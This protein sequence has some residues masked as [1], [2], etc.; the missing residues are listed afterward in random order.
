MLNNDIRITLDHESI[1]K[2]DLY[3]EL[4]EL[5]SAFC[6][7]GQQQFCIDQQ[8]ITREEIIQMKNTIQQIQTL[9]PTSDHHNNHH[10][11]QT[12][13][14]ILQHIINAY[15]DA[16]KLRNISNQLNEM[17]INQY[18]NEWHKL[19]HLLTIK[20]KDHHQLDFI[21]DDLSQLSQSWKHHHSSL[22]LNQYHHSLFSFTKKL[23]F[24]NQQQKKALFS[25][26]FISLNSPNYN[27]NNN[28]NR[29]TSLTSTEDIFTSILTSY[30]FPIG[31]YMVVIDKYNYS[32]LG[33]PYKK[34][35]T[36][37]IIFDSYQLSLTDMISIITDL[38][39]IFYD[40]FSATAQQHLSQTDAQ[41]LK[42][43][44]TYI[45]A[46]L[47]RLSSN[48]INQLHHHQHHHS[49]MN[50]PKNKYYSHRYS[51]NDPLSL[52]NKKEHHFSFNEGISSSSSYRLSLT[53][54]DTTHLLQYPIPIP[55]F[56]P[57]PWMWPDLI[58][59]RYPYDPYLFGL[60]KRHTTA[61]Q[62]HQS[63]LMKQF[64]LSLKDYHHPYYKRKNKRKKHHHH[65]KEVKDVDNN[66][67]N[68][69][70]EEEEDDDDRIRNFTKKTTLQKNQ[71]NQNDLLN[72]NSPTLNTTMTTS[73]INASK[74]K[75]RDYYADIELKKNDENNNTNYSNHSKQQEMNIKKSLSLL[76]SSPNHHPLKNEPSSHLPPPYTSISIE[77]LCIHLSKASSQFYNDLYI[78]TKLRHQEL[79]INL[80]TLEWELLNLYRFLQI[81]SS[82]AVMERALSLVQEM[83]DQSIHLFQSHYQQQEQQQEQEQQESNDNNNDNNDNNNSNN[84][85]T[86]HYKNDKNIN[87]KIGNMEKKKN[88]VKEDEEVVKKKGI[89]WM[90]INH[91]YLL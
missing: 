36:R 57:P 64:H 12:L 35:G 37:H 11:R 18:I 45:S 39:D 54:P 83:D 61:K 55:S 1:P 38:C 4:N 71:L 84:K 70:E 31:A 49:N 20:K 78:H 89:I 24:L 75:N 59:L 58:K 22:L 91:L 8:I 81:A 73:H 32:Q 79:K 90:M 33:F 53:S 48:I 6:S 46:Q 2:E 15:R 69:D 47:K 68:E 29:M 80:Q 82:N 28:N 66:N 13:I 63:L 21:L 51:M 60:I 67:N 14:I 30:D 23:N 25:S 7:E 16:L 77:Q 40:L 5:L 10:L 41:V 85:D 3:Q 72:T 26:T 65:K 19:N 9:L 17:T 87:E 52:K 34:I 86:I 43:K 50:R 74:G 56:T 27:H 76:L 62:Y 44:P 42:S 88:H